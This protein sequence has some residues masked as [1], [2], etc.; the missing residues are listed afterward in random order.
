[1]YLKRDLLHTLD[2]EPLVKS[3]YQ[4]SDLLTMRPPCFQIYWKGGL[5]RGITRKELSLIELSQ[6][7]GCQK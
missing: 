7:E 6:C 1:M 3:T 2:C 4:L 5:L